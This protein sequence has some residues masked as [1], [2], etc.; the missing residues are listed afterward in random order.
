MLLKHLLWVAPALL[1]ACD[2][3]TTDDGNPFCG[4]GCTDASIDPIN[5]DEG[6]ELRLEVIRADEGLTS[7]VRT[8][9]WFASDQDPGTRPF[10]RDP[11]TWNTTMPNPCTEMRNKMMFP[12]GVPRSRTYLDAGEKVTMSGGGSIELQ[13][14]MPFE[15][16][17]FTNTHEIGY[18]ADVDPADI[19]YGT[20]YTVQ[21]SGSASLPAG[22]FEGPNG[23]LYLPGDYSVD[24]PSF[25]DEIVIRP[26]EELAIAWTDNEP[27]DD[28]YLYAF[29]TFRDAL[30][31]NYMC[32]GPNTGVMTIPKEVMNDLPDGG[33]IQ[34]GLLSHRPVDLQGRRFD[35][36]GI[37]CHEAR[38]TRRN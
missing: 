9:A 38:F 24:V 16:F 29:V 5:L 11:V 28:A 17:I 20:E 30:G 32:V 13:R 15:D 27:R 18:Y 12:N 4:H 8:H 6:G 35:L 22:M 26:D 14:Q 33:F 36:F 1:L 7:E 31:L 21:W 37:S 2:G 25:D 3:E 19:T 23:K 10:F 34:H